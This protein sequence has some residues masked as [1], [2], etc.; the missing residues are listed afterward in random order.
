MKITGRQL[1]KISK[2]ADKLDIKVDTKADIETMGSDMIFHVI[3][4]AHTAEDEVA[5]VL[6]IFLNCKPEEALDIDLMG[7]WKSFIDSDKGKKFLSFF[8]SVATPKSQD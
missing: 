5:E 1:I 2:L 3:K 4:K 6:A 7:R 8:P